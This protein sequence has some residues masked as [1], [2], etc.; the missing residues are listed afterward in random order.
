M[1]SYKQY[2]RRILW[3]FRTPSPLYAVLRFCNNPPPTAYVIHLQL[4]VAL[5]YAFYIIAPKYQHV[6]HNLIV[7]LPFE[8]KN[9]RI[10]YLHSSCDLVACVG[11]FLN[12]FKPLFYIGTVRHGVYNL[13]IFYSNSSAITTGLYQFNFYFMERHTSKFELYNFKE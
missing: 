9:A 5:H 10:H 2:V 1:G 3:V 12:V 4:Y 6:C 7:P 13:I 11:T 8:L